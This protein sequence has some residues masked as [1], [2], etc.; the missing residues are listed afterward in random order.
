MLRIARYYSK[1]D[2]RENLLHRYVTGVELCYQP[3]RGKPIADGP[4]ADNS[5]AERQIYR[6]LVHC[7]S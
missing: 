5:V 6:N 3:R 4:I 1:E 2:K 7:I